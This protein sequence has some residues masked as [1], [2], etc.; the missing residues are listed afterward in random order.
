[1]R[2]VGDFEVAISDLRW[3]CNPDRLGFETTDDVPC[4][5]DIIGQDRALDAIRLGLEI[6][7]PGYNI[8]VSGLTGTGKSTTIKQLLQSIQHEKKELFDLCYVHNFRTPELPVCLSLPAGVGLVFKR[9]M[10]EVRKTLTEHIPKA[11]ESEPYVKKQ[12]EVV[13]KLKAR[14]AKLATSLEDLIAGKGFKFLEVQYGPFTRPVIVPIIDDKP[15]EMNKLASEVEA[16]KFDKK[17]FEKIRKDHESLMNKMEKFLK[18]TRELD[19]ELASQISELEVQFVRPIVDTC[20]KEERERFPY[21]KVNKYLDALS[22]YCVENLEIFTET[23]SKEDEPRGHKT[24]YLAFAVNVI[25]DNTQVEDVPVI[26]E[27]TP[28]YGNLFGTI[29]RVADGK[30]DFRTDFTMIRAGSMLRANGGFLVLSLTDVI[31]EP[32][33]W[34]ALKR[35]LKNNQ[36]SIHGFDSFLLMPVSA[37]KPEAIDIDVKVALIGD[38]ESYQILYYYDE[39]FQKVFKVKADFD[40]EMPNNQENI[41]KYAQFVRNILDQEELRP[42]HKTAVAAIAEEGARMAGRQDKVTTKFSDVADVIRE[43]SYWAKKNGDKMV[44]ADHVRQ[45]VAGR[46]HRVNLVEEKIREMLA[47]GTILL[48]SDGAKIGQIN[49]LSVYD[50][51]DHSFGKPVRITVETSMGRAGIINIEREAEMSGKTYNKGSLILEGYLRRK[52][53]QDKPLAMSASIC[54]EQSYGGVDGDSA[55]STEIYGLLSSLAD[56]PLRQ[57]LAVTGS[58]NQKGQIQPIGG[59]NEKIHGFFDICRIKGITGKQGVIIPRLNLVDLML[60]TDVVKAIE[61][62]KFHLYAIDTIE[63]GIELLTGVKAGKQRATGSFEKDSVCYLANEKLTR[64]AEQMK[65]FMDTGEE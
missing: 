38:A 49:G 43:A 14:R 28:T 27:T 16:G 39:D 64:F 61:E 59:V 42:F 13:E 46:V 37:L 22:E 40:S 5:T 62:S 29:E 9:R 1:M 45:A 57:D 18:A 12:K 17:G 15:I 33:V 65:D 53:A 23:K 50:L 6:D 7:S 60:R 58:V 35:A 56:L 63:E 32:A 11:L 19:L 20:L 55:S 24:S 26:I 2:S 54:F 51:G 25:V 36:I 3:R 52:F 31:V 48:D 41:R 10:A 34:P 8:Y 44:T 4:C 47:D 21:D 30:G